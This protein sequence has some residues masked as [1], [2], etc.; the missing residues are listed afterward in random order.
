M[1]WNQI[2]EKSWHN[3]IKRKYLIWLG[4]LAAFTE[5]ASFYSGS[6]YNF[7]NQDT[8]NTAN[9]GQASSTIANWLNAHMPEVLIVSAAFIIICLIILYISY[10]A[11]AGLIYGVNSVEEGKDGD[12][13]KD[14]A[15]GKKYFWRFIG[16]RA[17]IAI[18]LVLILILVV[19]AFVGAFVLAASYS[20]WL[21]IP[22]ALLCVPAIFG[23]VL[24]AVYV[25]LASALA[26]RYIVI[27]N[28]PIIESI[29]KSI[30]L[31]RQKLGVVVIAWLITIVINL[32]A[33]IVYTIVMIVPAI[34]SVS[35]GVASYA[36]GK[37][38]GLLIAVPLLVIILVAVSLFVQGLFVTY[39]SSYWTLVF[40]GLEK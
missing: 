1:N 6:G 17:L 34:A 9:F 14:F 25:S 39:I 11:R 15:A 30:H 35:I 23:F 16:L 26:E 22:I 18:T 40:K 7:S 36:I 29:D 20:S 27:K 37:T 13:H 31:V 12:F 28:L 5:G 38:T 10:S 21:M 33:G 4:V 3:L 32:V 2:L 8:E 19:L 24:L